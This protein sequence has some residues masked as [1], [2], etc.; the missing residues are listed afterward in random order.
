MKYPKYLG[1]LI[2]LCLASSSFGQFRVSPATIDM[3]EGGRVSVLTIFNGEE[4]FTL[5]QPPGYTF[6]VDPHD[7][8]VLFRSAD[9]RTAISF[10]VTTNSPGQLPPEDILRAAAIE[11]TPGSAFLQSSVCAT[12]YKAGCFVDLV[13][14]S[15][16]K[17]SVRFRHVY[18][19]CPE[20][21]A[22]FVFA[23]D[24]ED[25]DRQ[26][27]VLNAFLNSFRY[28]SSAGSALVQQ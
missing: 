25:F 15:R 20:G 3:A 16:E 10:Q 5:R 6:R 27:F 19:P 18:V 2:L 24:N 22:E 4:R 23:T 21:M 17:M 13:R 28:E 1:L 9:E 12:G 26:R 14:T 11:Q 8:S 7:K